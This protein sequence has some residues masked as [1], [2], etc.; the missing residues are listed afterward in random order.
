VKIVF[1]CRYVRA[2]GRHDGIS[3]YSAGIVAAL[4]RLHEVTM[5]V[6]DERQLALLPDLSWVRTSAPTSPLEPL[7]A[8][9]VNRLGPDIVFSPMQTMGSLGR[10]YRLVLTLHDLIYYRHRTPPAQFAWWLRLLWRVYHLAWWPQRV[11]LDR[12]DAVVTVSETTKSLMTQHRLTHRPV[13][14]V[15][16]AAD[17]TGAVPTTP[18]PRPEQGVL[19]YMGA[20]IA[21][22]NVEALV[23]AAARLPGYELHLMSKIA[24]A[25]RRRL[26]A[27]APDARLVFHDGVSDEE[28]DAVLRRAT[29]IVTASLDEG[30]GIPVIE[31]MRVGTPAVISDIPIFREIGGEAAVY[32]DPTDDASIVDA[33]RSLETPGEWEARSLA[34]VE[35]AARFSWDRSADVLLELLRDVDRR[36]RSTGA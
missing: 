21:Y 12:A 26:E 7:V 33:V 5:L 30:F 3:R 32:F 9:R 17:A 24:P 35:Q 13:T 15:Y 20:F 23:R 27:L 6:S 31:G 36:G 4:G 25:D 16:N 18:R 14:V 34:S 29:A 10:R 22:K 2:D 28:Y 1:D 19:V 8:L 11:L